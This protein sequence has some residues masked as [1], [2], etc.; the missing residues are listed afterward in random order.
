MAS[1]ENIKKFLTRVYTDYRRPT[2]DRRWGLVQYNGNALFGNL[3]DYMNVIGT[4]T[5]IN[6][7]AGP[8]TPSAGRITSGAVIG[9]GAYNSGWTA[10]RTSRRCYFDCWCRL[11]QT[12]DVRAWIGF[13]SISASNT[14]LSDDPVAHMAAFRWNP[15]VDAS[16]RTVTKDGVTQN[17]QSSGIATDANWHRFEIYENGHP[18]FTTTIWTFKID[19]RIVGQ[20]TTNLPGN[21]V[22]LTMAGLVTT[23]A[24][25]K[26]FDMSYRYFEC[27][28]EP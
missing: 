5:D 22:L 10:V 2:P 7:G 17:L 1:V 26:A 13:S 6:P 3:G 20:H 19:G 27:A 11:V 18:N 21:I 8:A 9:N 28:E 23:A 16:W 12:N 25:A 14:Y 15:A 4:I 24:V